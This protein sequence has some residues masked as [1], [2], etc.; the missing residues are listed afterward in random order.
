[1]P[2][3]RNEGIVLVNVGDEEA[4]LDFSA[5][6]ISVQTYDAQKIYQFS[7][8]DDICDMIMSSDRKEIIA[9]I[10]FIDNAHC[11]YS[12]LH[13]CSQVTW[14]SGNHY[15][16]PFF[17][18]NDEG[19]NIVHDISYVANIPGFEDEVSVDFIT[20]T[21]IVAYT[22]ERSKYV[23]CNYD[24]SNNVFI[25]MM[26]IEGRI[27][28]RVG[29]MIYAC[30]AEKL[31]A[32]AFS[33]DGID[34][35]MIEVTSEIFE[36]CYFF[37]YDI[38]SQSVLLYYADEDDGGMYEFKVYFEAEEGTDTFDILGHFP[39]LRGCFKSTIVK[40]SFWYMSLSRKELVFTCCAND[41]HKFLVVVR[42][43][44][45]QTHV[46]GDE[47]ASN[48][49]RTAFSHEFNNLHFLTKQFTGLEKKLYIRPV[50]YRARDIHFMIPTLKNCWSCTMPTAI[51]MSS[52]THI[53]LMSF[54]QEAVLYAEFHKC[55]VDECYPEITESAVESLH[56]DVFAVGMTQKEE[57]IDFVTLY[58]ISDVLSEVK[59]M[60]QIYLNIMIRVLY[61]SKDYFFFS[62]LG[63]N[64]LDLYRYN[65]VD[66]NFI[67]IYATEEHDLCRWDIIYATETFVN[68][69][70]EYQTVFLRFENNQ[71]VSTIYDGCAAVNHYREDA[72]MKIFDDS[73]V[74]GNVVYGLSEE[75]YF[76]LFLSPSLALLNTAIVFV[77]SDSVE[78]IYRFE[79]PVLHADFSYADGIL[80]IF[81]IID[82]ERS[83][84]QKKFFIDLDVIDSVE[85]RIFQPDY[86]SKCTFINT[87][88]FVNFN[89]NPPKV[90]NISDFF[91]DL[92]QFMNEAF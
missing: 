47:H 38:I 37:S 69:S 84:V 11:R 92:D 44:D 82:D 2:R 67:K 21:C 45:V 61:A 56:D 26:E 17:E 53:V 40:F 64:S 75:E 39:V 89:Y 46:F 49:R 36:V 10:E 62:F 8:V 80:T 78:H 33:D 24:K 12:N 65:V 9:D 74:F 6:G 32:Y 35:N 73:I 58:N 29:N 43:N 77:T 34:S 27:L 66:E 16:V 79:Q 25:A 71:W 18:V 88:N 7:T 60:Y 3:L 87:P 48:T 63:H 50:F 68:F 59:P 90:I 42:D 15:S 85:E 81:S 23:L 91:P 86:F 76:H 1:M 57:N 14:E 20:P 30:A 52:I 54:D 31:T 5:L 4:I 72:N 55:A 51:A 83:F 13:Y 70:C 41:S 28:G 22:F 19:A